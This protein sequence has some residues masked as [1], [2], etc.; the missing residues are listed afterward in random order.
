ME[1]R[2]VKRTRSKDAA[3]ARRAKRGGLLRKISK[4]FGMGGGARV[5]HG[6]RDV[7]DDE[8]SL[9][10]AS[11]SASESELVLTSADRLLLLAQGLGLDHT[12][13]RRRA[14]PTQ[15]RFARIKK[16]ATS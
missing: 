12:N 8:L 7:D 9:S 10:S 16:I 2:E 5:P 6:A 4:R 15:D 14:T 1:E 3:T 13:T 11:S